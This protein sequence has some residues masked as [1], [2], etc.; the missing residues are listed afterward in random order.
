MTTTTRKAGPVV[1]RT[2]AAAVIVALAQLAGWKLD[3]DLVD[4][5]AVIVSAAAPLVAGLL[6]RR[7]VTPTGRHQAG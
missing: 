5:L 4:A 2:A 3:G 1:T 6:A 7:H